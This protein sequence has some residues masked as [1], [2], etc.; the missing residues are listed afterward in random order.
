MIHSR[1]NSN[2]SQV[3]TV[4]ITSSYAEGAAHLFKLE[5]AVRNK[6]AFNSV[7]N[8]CVHLMPLIGDFFST[9]QH[10][11]GAQTT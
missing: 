6:Y 4:N 11:P 10:G 8:H 5:A 1:K 9:I 2:I 7:W 3:D